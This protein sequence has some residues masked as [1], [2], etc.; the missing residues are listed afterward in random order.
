VK[1]YSAEREILGKN[2]VTGSS[3]V[4]GSTLFLV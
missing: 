3:P 4:Q 2:E 1:C